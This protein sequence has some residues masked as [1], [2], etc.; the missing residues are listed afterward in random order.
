MAKSDTTLIEGAYAHAFARAELLSN[1]SPLLALLPFGV[2]RT[3]KEFDRLFSMQN[4][5]FELPV[6]WI[7]K[8]RTDRTDSSFI[9]IW[10]WDLGMVVWTGRQ[11]GRQIKWE[12]TWETSWEKDR[13]GGHNTPDQPADKTRDKKRA[14]PAR[15][16]HHSRQR[17]NTKKAWRTLRANYLTRK[18]SPR[19]RTQH[20]SQGGHTKTALRTPTVNCLGIISI[21]FI[22]SK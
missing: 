6:H 4:T 16:T 13:E 17:R 10:L 7:A 22:R 1:N 15:R 14:R 2:H 12:T 20:P 11:R 5:R 21:L 19:R 9:Y 18:T 3:R 8:T